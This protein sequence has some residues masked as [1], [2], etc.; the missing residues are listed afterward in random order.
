MYLVYSLNSLNFILLPWSNQGY[1]P[2]K[3][4]EARGG[5]CVGGVVFTGLPH[6]RVG[7]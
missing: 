4:K 6:G 5:V 7:M 3:V 1:G 2:N